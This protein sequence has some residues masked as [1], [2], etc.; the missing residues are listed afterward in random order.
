MRPRS[1]DALRYAPT[2]LQRVWGYCAHSCLNNPQSNN[3]CDMAKNKK[4]SFV[5]KISSE[6]EDFELMKAFTHYGD[7]FILWVIDNMKRLRRKATR[8]EQSV[9]KYMFKR[10]II[11][12][13]QAPF[14]FDMNG[15]PKCYF[16]DFYVPALKIIIEVD[17][18]TH[19]TEEQIEYDIRRDA[20][21]RSIG[22]NTIR[23]N[24]NLVFQDKYRHMI[25]IPEEKY[26]R[27][28]KVI[29]LSEDGEKERKEK[30]IRE[31]L[32][33]GRKR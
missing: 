17:G 19:K 25:P 15:E 30:L 33:K 22:I 4:V 20:T 28:M 11:Y 5:E 26:L 24:A 8:P 16:A 29:Y 9:A 6:E 27:P 23:I 14:V 12:I 18:N 1:N 31:A 3:I 10:R 13:S 21:F 2:V 7:K 32:R